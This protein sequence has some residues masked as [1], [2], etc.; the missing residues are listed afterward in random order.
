MKDMYLECIPDYKDIEKWAELS[1][2]YNASFEYNEFFRPD[3]LDDK[4]LTEEIIKVYSSLG[5]NMKNDT[6]HGAFLDICINSSDSM[7]KKASDYRVEQGLDIAARL[8][9]KAVVFHTNYLTGFS[10]KSY[11][12]SWVERNIEYWSKKLEKYSMLNIYIENMFDESPELLA[13]LSRKMAE[14]K[15]FGICFDIAHANLT[16][17]A[18]EEWVLAFSE[19]IRHLHINDNDGKEDL[20]MA[21]GEGIIDWEILKNE[22][23]LRN[24]PSLLIEV[25]GADKFEKSISYLKDKG[26]I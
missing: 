22:T 3:L 23:L 21:V 7:I 2:K 10:L 6:L 24:D 26:L 20:H 4:M 1:E 9:V 15:R 25:S 16:N 13:R 18:I 8:G 19:G 5:R 17:I 12:D 14:Q 11:R